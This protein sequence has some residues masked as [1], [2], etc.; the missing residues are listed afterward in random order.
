MRFLR[1]L[2]SGDVRIQ[3]KQ[4]KEAVLILKKMVGAYERNGVLSFTSRERNAM[5]RL[6][7]KFTVSGLKPYCEKSKLTKQ[8]IVDFNWAAKI[9]I[10][11]D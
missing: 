2:W 7:R 1:V 11:S 8:A 10:V 6:K 5:H 9:I 4:G 3:T